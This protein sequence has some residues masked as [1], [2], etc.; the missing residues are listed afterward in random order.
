LGGAGSCDSSKARDGGSNREE[1]AIASGERFW[2]RPM[3]SPYLLQRSEQ[4]KTLPNQININ[5]YKQSKIEAIQNNTSL[6]FCIGN[7]GIFW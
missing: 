1:R 7:F 6:P 4:N 2:D 5:Q 3:V